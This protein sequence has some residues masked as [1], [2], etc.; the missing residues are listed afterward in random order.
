M[1]GSKDDHWTRKTVGKRQSARIVQSVPIIH[2]GPPR[3]G[4]C[5]FDRDGRLVYVTL[6]TATRYHC[7]RVLV[8]GNLSTKV[9]EG[10]WEHGKE[11]RREESREA[12]REAERQEGREAAQAATES[13]EAGAKRDRST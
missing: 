3:R 12:D 10:E 2:E 9:Y 5:Y 1:T 11:S 8:N 6:A 7:R 13:Q 4:K